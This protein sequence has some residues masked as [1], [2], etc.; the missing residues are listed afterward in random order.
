MCFINLRVHFWQN[1]SQTAKEL[2][3]IIENAETEYQ[4]CGSYSTQTFSWYKNK[5]FN[6]QD[7]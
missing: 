4:V 7:A 6:L 5:S 2:V 1:E 3:K